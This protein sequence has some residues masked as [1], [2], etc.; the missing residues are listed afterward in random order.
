LEWKNES[1]GN[2]YGILTV[3]TEAL[4]IPLSAIE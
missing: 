4:D 1:V 2:K 3:C